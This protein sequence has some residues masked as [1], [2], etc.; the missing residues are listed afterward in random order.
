MALRTT[1]QRATPALLA[2]RLVICVSR[3][4]GFV[5]KTIKI[6]SVG[7]INSLTKR[8]INTF[9]CTPHTREPKSVLMDDTEMRHHLR[10]NVAFLDESR[11][12][13]GPPYTQGLMFMLIINILSGTV[14]VLTQCRACGWILVRPHKI[15]LLLFCFASRRSFWLNMAQLHLKHGL[16]RHT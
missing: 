7:V 10:F 9:T 15:H 13:F 14:V 3:W 1:K 5:Q 8:S 6:Q 4:T 2:S 16:K 11:S 12:Q